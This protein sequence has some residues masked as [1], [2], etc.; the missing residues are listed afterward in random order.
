MRP[1]NHPTLI[2]G[3]VLVLAA[4]G[5]GGDGGDPTQKTQGGR[6]DQSPGGAS[7]SGRGNPGICIARADE[8][9]LTLQ[10]ATNAT[11]GQPVWQQLKLTHIKLND[12]P[13]DLTMLMLGA[14]KN[15]TLAGD[16]LV[17]TAA[18]AFG[19]VVEGRYS[20][21]VEAPGYQPRAY[22]VDAAFAGRSGSCPLTLSNGTK[23][24]VALVPG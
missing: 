2:L 3:L 13:A 17:C 18:C 11:S 21:T 8:P 1:L 12:Q 6:D 19:G 15:V 9:V 22:V 10:T 14:S 20:F 7:Q 24:D 4:C 16:A 23:L 5:G